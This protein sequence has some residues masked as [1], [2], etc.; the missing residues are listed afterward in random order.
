[1][2]KILTLAIALAGLFISQNSFA[3]ITGT[4]GVCVGSA[5]TLHDSLSGTGTWST[6]MP[7]IATINATT[8]S[9]TGISAGTCTVTFSGTGGISTALFTVS[10]PPA[11]ITGAIATICVGSTVTYGCTST[12]GYW[13][14]TTPSVATVGT[15]TGVVYGVS[16][17][18]SQ[19]RY[20]AGPGCYS[21]GNVAV[22]T[23]SYPDT[24]SGTSA[25]CVGSSITLTSFFAG[26]TWVSSAPSV[27]SVTT[28]GGVVSGVS[29]G[30]AII[31]HVT[32][33]TCGTVYGTH[34]VTVTTTTSPGTITGTMSLTTGSSTT[35]TNS[36]TGGTWSSSN[37]SVA[38]I[39]AYGVVNAV[40]AGTTTITYSV[41]GCSGPAYTT[42]VVTVTAPNCISGDLLF[43]GAPYW[44][45]AKVWL[46]KYDATTH[47]LT[48]V[49]STW[50][51]G[52]G[53]SAHYS[54]CGMGTDT[55]RVKAADDSTTSGFGY[56]P[57][58]HNSSAYWYA[59]N[60][61]WHVAGTNDIN[62]NITMMYGTVTSGPGFIAGDV[63]TGANKGT[64]DGAPAVGMLIYCVNDMTGAIMQ[65]TVTD[66]AGHYTFSN[67]PTGATYR[68]YPEEINYATTAYTSINLTSG[69][70][71]MMAANF[72]QHTLSMTIT[73]VMVGVG[74]VNAANQNIVV[75]PNPA[76]NTLNVSWDAAHTG[77]ATINI[78]DVTGRN[79]FSTTA[80]MS[81]GSSK[82]DLSGMTP[83][84]YMIQIKSE[85]INYNAKVEIK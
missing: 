85:G 63:T 51:Y 79:V 70:P 77:N 6:S 41:T 62:K 38:P 10:A 27:A 2:K 67:L 69:T 36:V 9:I 43:T 7:S 33:G 39:S 12:G 23:T 80:N 35:L 5:T 45:S 81:N 48:A 22:T 52:T 57:T 26:G 53:T 74:N 66:A 61:I 20:N 49:D 72:I 44:G 17:G 42:A 59:A 46:I 25:V 34:T 31:S 84:L 75:F 14:S 78:A 65:R 24:V 28:T 13:S 29:A 16:G 50:A 21:W 40:S 64:A 4:M 56:L 76:S 1:M 18:T 83:G 73:P 11:P 30:T 71:S 58:Y 60:T 32:A 19:I 3:A 37:P 68:I 47:L 54:F 8:G 82:L 55:F 15:S